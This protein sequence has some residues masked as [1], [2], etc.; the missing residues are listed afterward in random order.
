MTQNE[1]GNRI[2]KNY[3]WY[4][5]IMITACLAILGYLGVMI[6]DTTQASSVNTEKIEAVKEK[7]NSDIIEIAGHISEKASIESVNA[8]R[9][10]CEIWMKNQ[11]E[12]I[13]EIKELLKEINRKIDK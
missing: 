11:E 8:H 4:V 13:K 3:Q 6:F 10:E 9:K 1:N 12:D 2:L 5:G 7:H